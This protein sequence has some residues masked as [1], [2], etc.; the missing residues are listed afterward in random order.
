[1]D[2]CNRAYPRILQKKRVLGCAK[3]IKCRKN[4]I[5][6][7]ALNESTF[8]FPILNAGDA[9]ECCHL[10]VLVKPPPPKLELEVKSNSN[11]DIHTQETEIRNIFL[12]F[13]FPSL[14]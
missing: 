3:L 12:W 5:F 1:M 7:C 10:P 14:C 13:L 9:P 4:Q 2:G 11:L 8:A 6:F